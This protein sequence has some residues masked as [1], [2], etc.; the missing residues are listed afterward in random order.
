M[1]KQKSAK[2][3]A[4]TLPPVPLMPMTE[5]SV[6]VHQGDRVKETQEFKTLAEQA[7]KSRIVFK[8]YYLEEWREKYKHFD[9]MKR[10]DKMFPYAKL[11]ENSAP[12]MVF[13]DE[14]KTEY[15]VD[16]CYQKAKLLRQMGYKY[17]VIEEDTTLFDVL[18][19]LGA[20]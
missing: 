10:I 18:E 12:C 2:I 11:S 20:I 19:Q 7:A 3:A 4:K 13:I 17:A 16:I 6:K 1:M 15:D 8:N 5:R 9:R 14:P